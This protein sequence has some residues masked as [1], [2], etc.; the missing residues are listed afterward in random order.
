MSYREDRFY[1]IFT[2]IETQGLQK[3][4]SAQLKK[5]REQDKHKFLDALE[6]QE[7]AF[8]RIQGWSPNISGKKL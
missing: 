3:K 8:K 7:Y 1:E 5:M 4:F 6:R 2:L